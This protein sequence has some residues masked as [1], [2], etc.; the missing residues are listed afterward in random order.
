MGGR[1]IPNGGS[2]GT[3]FGHAFYRLRVFTGDKITGMGS[4]ESSGDCLDSMWLYDPS[5]IDE[6]LRHANPIFQTAVTHSGGTCKSRTFR[7]TWRRLPFTGLA[8][9]WGRLGY[10]KAFTFVAE[11]SHR[12]VVHIAPLPRSLPSPQARVLLRAAVNSAAGKPSGVC[13]VDRR[14]RGSERWHWLG[15]LSSGRAAARPDSPLAEPRRC[16][17][18]SASCRIPAGCQPIRAGCRALP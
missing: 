15:E 3:D 4:R 16:N 10:Q 11:V 5:V 14:A 12:T 9:L 7:W 18:A 8:T 1:D 6:T 2:S 13:A 17:C